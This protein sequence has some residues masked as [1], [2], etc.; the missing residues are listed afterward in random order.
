MI[1]TDFTEIIP[2]RQLNKL[3]ILLDIIFL[4]SLLALLLIKKRYVAVLFGIF[5]GILYFA[6]DY[7]IFYK[8]LETRVVSGANPFWFLLWLSMSYGFTNFVWIWLWLDHD[9]NLLEW[10]VYIPIGWLA[11]VLISANFGAPFGEIAIS[12]GTGSYHGVMALILFLS[13]GIV[14]IHNMVVKDKSEKWPLVWM[15]LIGILVQFSWEFIL[16]I[17][18]I[19]ATGFGPLI[20]NSL[21]ETNLGIPI[22]YL[23]YIFVTKK[24][25]NKKCNKA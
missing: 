7:G 9:E 22:I 24:I 8:V 10:S 14:I 4:I 17:T 5:G 16:L 18:G 20:V 12:R 15:L 21:L 3:Y 23:I 1:L 19:R 6:V 2:S 13:Y 25:F 11:V